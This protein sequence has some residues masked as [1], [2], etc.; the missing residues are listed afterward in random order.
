MARPCQYDIEEVYSIKTNALRRKLEVPA[1]GNLTSKHDLAHA[2][3][4][5]AFSSEADVLS[6]ILHRAERI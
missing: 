3:P 5:S 2:Q 1:K 6:K 4:N